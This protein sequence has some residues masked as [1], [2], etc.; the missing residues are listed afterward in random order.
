MRDLLIILHSRSVHKS[1]RIKSSLLAVRYCKFKRYLTLTY[2]RNIKIDCKS[3][4]LLKLL[5]NFTD[6]K[7]YIIKVKIFL[8]FLNIDN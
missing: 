3:H 5:T 6:I 8:I 7:R 1:T 4:Y 2:D